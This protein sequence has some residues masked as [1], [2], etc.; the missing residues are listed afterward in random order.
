MRRARGRH[1]PGV[2]VRPDHALSRP[3]RRRPRA[4]R[5]PSTSAASSCRGAAGRSTR[6]ALPRSS[7]SVKAYFVLKLMGD[8]PNAPHMVRARETILCARRHRSLQLLHADL[9]RDLRP[10]LVGRLPGRAAGDRAAAGLVRLQHLQDVLLVA[11]HRRAA[12]DHLGLEALSARCPTSPRSRSSTSSTRR[13]R[14]SRARAGSATGGPSSSRSTTPS[15]GSR[16]PGMTPLRKKALAACEQW[17]HERLVQSDGLGAIFPPDHQHDHRVPLPRLRDGRPAA[18]RSRSRSSSGSS[19][20]TRRRS[21]SSPASPP[22]WDTALVMEA[23]SDGG[24]AGRRPGDAQ[25]RPLA[26]RPG[27]QDDR[28]LARRPAPRPSPAAGTSSTPT[29]GTPT[30]TTRPRS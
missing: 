2:R 5:P 26:A 1:H 13:P 6:A 19:S 16:R 7:S 20:R 10:V 3:R 9:S 15:S 25:G 8:D 29:S 27:G 18:R 21:T 4:G 24:T 11:R 28:R 23:L 30:P 12:L 22:I 17:I 14:T